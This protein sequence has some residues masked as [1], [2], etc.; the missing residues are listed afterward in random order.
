MGG[1][2]SDRQLRD[3][4]GVLKVRGQRLD[5][6][7]MRRMAT[8]LGVLDPLERALALDPKQRYNDYRL[9]QFDSGFCDSLWATQSFSAGLA[10]TLLE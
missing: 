8:G 1:E 6:G 10:N 9:A 4:L 7:Y 5:F 2:R 3:A